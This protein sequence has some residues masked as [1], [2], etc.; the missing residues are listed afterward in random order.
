MHDKRNVIQKLKLLKIKI[1]S[2]LLSSTYLKKAYYVNCIQNQFTSLFSKNQ[3]EI[4]FKQ[5]FSHSL[6]R[7]LIKLFI[8]YYDYIKTIQILTLI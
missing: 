5:L 7:I 1:L 4:F 2:K 8:R 6:F 3:T